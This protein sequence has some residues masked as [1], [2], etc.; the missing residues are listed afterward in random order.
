MRNFIFLNLN[1]LMFSEPYQV[2]KR[3]GFVYYGTFRPDRL[4]YLKRYFTGEFF[5]STSKKN[6]K[7]FQHEGCS[8]KWIDKLKWRG[9]R[10]NLS[11]FRYS[12]YVED[13]YTHKHFNNLAN[14]FFE[15]VSNRVVL[16]FDRSCKGTVELSGISVDD[17]FFVESFDEMKAV[18]DQH[19]FEALLSM[20][21]YFLDYCRQEKAKVEEELKSLFS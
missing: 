7:R 14:R 20:Q 3:R 19:G 16:F 18:A 2:E 12:I 5:V 11:Q 13:A 8:A 21:S 6:I 10:G 15:C 1:A 17:I 4:D 9:A